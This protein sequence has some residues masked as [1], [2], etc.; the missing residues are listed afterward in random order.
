MTEYHVLTKRQEDFWNKTVEEA[1]EKEEKM[2]VELTVK[3]IMEEDGQLL[4]R[5]LLQKEEIMYPEEALMNVLKIWFI[6]TVLLLT[7]L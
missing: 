7:V 2:K 5:H 1:F 6:H 4:L 3:S